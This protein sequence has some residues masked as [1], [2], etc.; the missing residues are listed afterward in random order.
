MEKALREEILWAFFHSIYKNGKN[1]HLRKE[2]V[3][4]HKCAFFGS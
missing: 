2:I 3:F 4:L 1:L